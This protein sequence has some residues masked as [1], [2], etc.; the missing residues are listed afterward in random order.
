MQKNEIGLLGK[1]KSVYWAKLKVTL[2]ASYDVNSIRYP[3]GYTVSSR[4]YAQFR[5]ARNPLS[6]PKVNLKSVVTRCK[7][8]FGITPTPIFPDLAGDAVHICVRI[9]YINADTCLHL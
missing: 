8:C 2:S 6:G 3:L 7:S 9:E 1:I 4:V 5:M